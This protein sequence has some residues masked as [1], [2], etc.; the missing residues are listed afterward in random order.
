MELENY[1]K[2]SKGSKAKFLKSKGFNVGVLSRKGK[3]SDFG[4]MSK[5][6]E[7]EYFAQLNE[8]LSDA[9]FN[10][11]DIQKKINSGKKSSTKKAVAAP[12]EA[13]FFSGDDDA[14]KFGITDNHS[15]LPNGEKKRRMEI[16]LKEG[17]EKDLG[18]INKDNLSGS[19]GKNSNTAWNGYIASK[20]KKEAPGPD[21]AYYDKWFGDD[22]TSASLVPDISGII[23]STGLIG[24]VGTT[25]LKHTANTLANGYGITDDG[26]RLFET[27]TGDLSNY[28]KEGI[29][30]G[31]KSS[32]SRGWDRPKGGGPR[33]KGL[34]G[35]ESWGGLGKNNENLMSNAVPGMKLDDDTDL[36]DANRKSMSHLLGYAYVAIDEYGNLVME[37]KYDFSTPDSEKDNKD[38][39]RPEG[40]TMQ[41][42]LDAFRGEKS[43]ADTDY[44]FGGFHAV[45]DKYGSAMPVKINLG[46][47]SDIL[48]AAEIAELP[49]YKA[50]KHQTKQQ[51]SI[52]TA[53]RTVGALP[54]IVYDVGK[55]ALKGMYKAGRTSN[56]FDKGGIIYKK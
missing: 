44:K 55:L 51:S 53:Y 41:Q 40:A 36:T 32:I 21:R 35:Y 7:S 31:I 23:K 6:A 5:D 37:D 16:L 48:T 20:N 18:K 47:A 43:Y 19:Y 14:G 38:W 4:K 11:T 9:R 54:S 28:E 8:V 15:S 46:K 22:H 49:K 17:F 30:A 34:V 12:Q 3:D 24:S 29:I 45:G 33:Q 1:N 39:V 42:V 56:M 25:Y 50:T 10:S 27:N 52:K 2:M 26:E 13:G